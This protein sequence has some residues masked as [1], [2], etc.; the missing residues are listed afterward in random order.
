MQNV[1]NRADLPFTP[2]H[3]GPGLLFKSISPTK[4][5]LA[6]FVTTQVLIDFETLYFLVARE[7]PVHRFFHSIPGSLLVGLIV[8]G[9]AVLGA[10]LIGPEVLEFFRVTDLSRLA[11]VVGGTVG[12]LSH[13]LLDNLMHDDS[14]LFYPLDSGP[15]LQGLIGLSELHLGC[16]ASGLVG[17]SVLAWR[18]RRA[19]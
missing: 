14:R 19:G 8:S 7:W 10:H 4:F 18:F 12:G 15:H 9:I 16:L 17:L 2:F 6:A 11:I 5:S 3:F 13:A 1:A